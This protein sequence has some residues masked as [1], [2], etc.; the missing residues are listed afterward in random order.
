MVEFLIRSADA[1]RSWLHGVAVR[2]A[3]KAQQQASKRR[4]R[5]LAAA[6]PEAVYPTLPTADWWA[7]VDDELR[8]LPDVWRQVILVCDIGGQSRSK[9]SLELGWPEGTVAKRLA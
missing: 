5:Q 7:V 2:V 9:A 6:K 3:R 1:V 8:Q 4:A